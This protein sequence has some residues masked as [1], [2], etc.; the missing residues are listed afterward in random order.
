MNNMS[1]CLVVLT[2]KLKCLK[3]IGDA[4]VTLISNTYKIYILRIFVYLLK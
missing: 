3:T 1:K 2:K 4:M